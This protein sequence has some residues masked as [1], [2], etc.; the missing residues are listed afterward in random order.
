MRPQLTNTA[1]RETRIP[2]SLLLILAT[3]TAIGAA[4]LV[5]GSAPSASVLL[6]MAI[7]ATLLVPI[8]VRI[9]QGR[10]DVFEPPVVFLLAY[11]TLFVARPLEMISKH[12][13]TYLFVPN[14][15]V[16]SSFNR[17]LALALLG[18][19]AFAVG[20]LL[21]W[22]RRLAHFVPTPPDRFEEAKARWI[23]GM[24][25]ALGG[26]AFML[27]VVKGGG[28]SAL[29]VAL[30]GRTDQ[31]LLLYDQSPAYLTVGSI[32]LIGP[33][34]LLLALWMRRRSFLTGLLA[35]L[36]FAAAIVVRGSSGSRIALVPLF[37]AL[38]IFWYVG[39]DRRPS[40]PTTILVLITAVLL[41][42]TIF[43]GREPKPGT[44]PVQSYADGFSKASSSV[45][46]AVNPLIESAD[47]SMAPG[48][49][50]SM[51]V[52]PDKIGYGYG[53]FVLTDFLTRPVP[54]QLWPNKPLTPQAQVTAELAPRPGSRPFLL[55]YSVL[56]HGYLDFGM[57]GGLWLIGYGVACRVLYEWFR[58]HHQSEVAMASFAI[59]L[60]LII[61]AVRDGP[62]DTLFGLFSLTLPILIAWYVSRDRSSA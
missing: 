31:L 4:A 9:S 27:F 38:F 55:A 3:A 56:L 25:A 16:T 37:G 28:L 34:V 43:Y 60:P 26:L 44:G 14:F 12:D 50:A 21:P 1:G 33:T 51:D 54:R 8:L 41:S 45:G 11:G 23:A 52:I 35:A 29:G 53:R 5:A 49:A 19:A 13:F 17:M 42:S 36:M 40:V 24:V 6:V 15:D 48:L 22:G 10:F 58:L 47:A 2:G 62:V 30:G 61:Q 20:Y 39:R 59:T 46:N 18:A 32:L 7:G 57:L